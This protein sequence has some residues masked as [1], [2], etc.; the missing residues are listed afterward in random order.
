MKAIVH[1]KYG[2]PDVLHLKEVEKPQ[3][4]DNEVLIKIH[5]S[6]VNRTDC[7]FRS[8]KPYVVRFF[9][10]LFKPK[11]PILGCELS[12]TIEVVGKNV[13]K[14][15]VGDE[16]FG[17]SEDNHFG[18][19]AEY[20]CLPEDKPIVIKP[21]NITHEQAAAVSEGAWY[22]M[23]YV[24]LIDFTK[25]P[26]PKILING[27]TGAIGSA[28]LQLCKH[29]GA[30][31][32]AVCNTKN[33]ELIKSLGADRIIDYQKEDFTKVLKEEFDYVFDA[34]GKSSFKKCK[35]LVKNHGW[36]SA[37]ELGPNWSNVYLAIWTKIFGSI[38]GR[39]V[40][41]PIPGNPKEPILLI[42]NLIEEGKYK[43][44]IDKVYPLEEVQT[45]T[46]YVETG[47]KTGAVVIKIV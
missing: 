15:K 13:R 46:E 36:Y 11:M 40:L 7:G 23:T 27:T 4:K 12:G 38:N 37:T 44:I 28:A 16:V 24:N 33:I 20:I 32:T 17:M 29:F 45:A 39:R 18:T 26:K 14:F 9:S 47:E 43:P 41:F 34:V 25:R 42:K 6:T 1:T 35:R 8:G 31:V 30:E 2:A 3:P 19:H 10:G 21:K 5:A 22:A